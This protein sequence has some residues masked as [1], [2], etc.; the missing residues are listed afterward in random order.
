MGSLL[1]WMNKP[2][3]KIA[4]LAWNGFLDTM[5]AVTLAA[6]LAAVIAIVW[7]Y[8]VSA[9]RRR[10]F[11]PGDLFTAYTPL[12][13][14][15]LAVPAG[16]LAGGFCFSQYEDMLKFTEGRMGL[17]AQFTML[18]IVLS[19]TI[20]YFLIVAVGPLTPAKFRGRPTHPMA[21]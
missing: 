13:W 6:L 20:S 7:L 8:A 12:W 1:F 16:L 14:L 17:V 10:V 9:R 18:V 3:P 5:A 2:D 19:A 4:D 11:F 15:L 21:V